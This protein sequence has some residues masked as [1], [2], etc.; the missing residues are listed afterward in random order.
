MNGWNGFILLLCFHALL[1]CCAPEVACVDYPVFYGRCALDVSHELS[2]VLTAINKIRLVRVG[3]FDG[4]SRV[5]IS[6]L[7]KSTEPK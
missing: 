6:N 4:D 3:T 1:C 5:V 2:S 7:I